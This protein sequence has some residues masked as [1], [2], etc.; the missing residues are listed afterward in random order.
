LKLGIL[1]D[2]HEAA[3]PLREAIGRLR[4]GGAERFVLLGDVF[5]N[6]RNLDEIIAI[7]EEVKIVGVFGNHELGICLD[8]DEGM[9][10]RYA[11]PVFDFFARLRGRHE[12][13]D[14]LFT[15][16]QAWMDPGDLD[17][18]WYLHD[19]PETA[20]LLAR[21]FAATDRRVLFQG[22]YHRWL[23]ATESGPL[24]WRGEGPLTLAP[25]RRWL[26]V[27]H[28]VLNGWCARYD[29]DTS[30]LTPVRLAS[31]GA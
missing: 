2:V 22:H 6:G 7:L 23:A 1:A 16:T 3:A 14:C 13:G 28:A 29:T 24:P 9:R 31:A 19:L 20:E 18:P 5:E 12:E 4:G 26:V 15:H 11:G 10:Q 17:Q 30:E 25:G 21:N 8:P 27:V